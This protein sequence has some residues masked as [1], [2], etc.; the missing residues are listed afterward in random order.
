[1]CFS[2]FFLSPT[3]YSDPH[4]Q[5]TNTQTPEDASYISTSL[6]I[7][8]SPPEDVSGAGTSTSIG[9]T[10]TTVPKSPMNEVSND[11]LN[12][13]TTQI[14]PIRTCKCPCGRTG[15]QFYVN[16]TLQQLS[17]IME[18]TK[19]EL[20]VNKSQLSSFIRKK[21]SVKDDR[22]TSKTIGGIGVLFLVFI[23]ILI[24]GIDL[25]RIFGKVSTKKTNDT[26]KQDL[27]KT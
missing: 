5:S 14:I 25:L 26:G 15:N 21:I 7:P 20:Q 16:L 13:T 4:K 18:E 24:I 9:R 19:K 23:A 11:S 2:D 27:N 1:M 22:P 12:M 8:T 3:T 17:L 10:N 6:I